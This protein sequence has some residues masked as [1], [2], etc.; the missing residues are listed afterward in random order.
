MPRNQDQPEPS[1]P[2]GEGVMEKPFEMKI[3]LEMTENHP[4]GL[5]SIFGRDT[6]EYYS[7]TAEKRRLIERT[8]GEALFSLGLEPLESSP[9]K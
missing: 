4:S 1:N 7:L 6:V 5:K 3:V 9:K 8:V 2:F